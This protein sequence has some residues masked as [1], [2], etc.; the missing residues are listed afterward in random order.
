MTNIHSE[1][2]TIFEIPTPASDVHIAMY[3]RVRLSG[4]QTNPEAFGSTYEREY[5]F[6]DSTWISRVNTKGRC[7]LMSVASVLEDNVTGTEESAIAI[8]TLSVLG[9]EM[10]AGLPQDP[11]Y[12]QHIADEE[13]M[14]RVDVYMLVGM[15][16]QP[17]YR[18]KGVGRML[19]DRALEVVKHA[20]ECAVGNTKK[21]VLLLVHDDQHDAMHLYRKAGFTE[22][23]RVDHEE[24]PSTW[25]ASTVLWTVIQIPTPA[26]EEHTALYKIIRLSAL[27]TDPEV[28]ASSYESESNLSDRTWSSRVNTEGRHTLVA[29]L[30]DTG[31]AIGTL[32]V[33]GPEM[34]AWLPKER[35]YPP[36]LAEDEVSGETDVYILVGMWV[37]PEFRGRGVGRMLVD[38]ALKVIKEAPSVGFQDAEEYLRI[39]KRT[40]LLLVNDNWRPAKRLYRKA[41]FVEQEAMSDNDEKHPADI[42]GDEEENDVEEDEFD[43]DEKSELLSSRET[44]PSPSDDDDDEDPRL[45]RAA[46]SHFKR[47]ALLVFLVFLFW[48][49]YQMRRSMWEGKRKPKVIHASR[50]SKEH[51]FR[52]AA[53]PIITETLKD[54]RVRLR[55]ALPEPT[56]APKPTVKPKKKTRTGKVSAKRKARQ[57]KRKTSTADKRM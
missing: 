10:L 7:T 36:S 25:M 41:R 22:Q 5:S 27:L 44:S 17:E 29:V 6:P 43:A 48:L 54:G 2:R 55:G 31:S 4:L 46:P 28:A 18:G 9:P 1:R 57:A 15:W 37:Q 26:S 51:K 30:V 42:S 11:P 32:S 47:F 38:R 40:A 45:N 56:E 49:G 35:P 52:P 14:G 20:K 33:H 8:G 3:K 34:L 21:V 19:V 50:Y 53:S 12:P 24:K 23:E 39:K 13:G 16:V